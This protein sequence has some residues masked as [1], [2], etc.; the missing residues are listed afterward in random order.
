MQQGVHRSV[1]LFALAAALAAP[2]GASTQSTTTSEVRKFEVVSVAG[3]TLVVREAAGPREYTVPEDFRFEVDGKRVPIS[4]L[5]PGMT[6]QATFTTTTTYKPVY[7]TEVKEAEVVQASANSLLVRGQDGFHMY[8]IGDIEKRHI[9]IMKDGKPAEFGSLSRGD[10]LTATIVTE[11]PPR[12]ITQTQVDAV[13]AGATDVLDAAASTANAAGAAAGA[14][15]SAAAE[16]AGAAA[17]AAA[18]AAGAA[19]NATA[20][21]AQQAAAA[22][23]DAAGSGRSYLLVLLVIAVVAVGLYLSMRSQG[24]TKA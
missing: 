22:A 2:A 13:L 24:G 16:T 21:A 8:S 7:V 11:G 10:R 14:A 5:R 20:E 17:G 3:N 23:E 6:G 15:A 9:T 18:D 19:A 4:A 12:A 1:V